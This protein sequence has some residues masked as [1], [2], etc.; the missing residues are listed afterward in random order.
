MERWTGKPDCGT[1]RL[2]WTICGAV[3][4]LRPLWAK[5]V[6]ML[7]CNPQVGRSN[8][9]TRL[10][11]PLEHVNPN[12]KTQ[13][14]KVFIDHQGVLQLAAAATSTPMVGEL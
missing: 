7:C 11:F 4:N 10:M 14:S 5:G 2:G 13:L 12:Q 9:L 8:S 3:K 6:P 1:Q